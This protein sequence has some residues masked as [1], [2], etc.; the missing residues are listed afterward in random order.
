MLTK[1]RDTEPCVELWIEILWWK[2]EY[3]FFLVSF[4]LR[5]HL[6]KEKALVCGPQTLGSDACEWGKCSVESDSLTN[7]FSFSVP[8]DEMEKVLCVGLPHDM[9]IIQWKCSA[10]N[11]IAA[12]HTKNSF[13]QLPT[14]CQRE[15]NTEAKWW[16]ETRNFTLSLSHTH[17][18]GGGKTPWRIGWMGQCEPSAETTHSFEI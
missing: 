2:L 13:H 10:S 7:E 3:F 11:E 9:P 4:L 6:C 17:T 15:K 8:T 18:T 1:M 12:F 14:H 16:Q 5:C